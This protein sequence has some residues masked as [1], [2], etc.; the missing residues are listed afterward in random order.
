[1]D[2]ASIEKETARFWIQCFS[3]LFISGA[4]FQV[5]AADWIF[6]PNLTVREVFSDNIRQD[7]NNKKSALVTEVDPG[8][9]LRTISTINTFNLRYRMQNLYNAGGNSNIDINHQLALNSKYRLIRNR[10][11]VD[12]QSSISQQNTSNRRIASD[13]LTGGSNTTVTT[14]SISPYWTPHFKG[15][16]TGIVRLRYNRISTSGG[17]QN[18]SDTNTYSESIRFNSGHDFSRF[19]WSASFNNQQNQRSNGNDV[20]F[21]SS[22]FRV[23]YFFTRKLSS[24]IQVGHQSNQF[25]STT[26]S[27]R[28]GLYYTAGLFWRPSMRFSVQAGYGNN[29]FVTVNISPI[30]RITWSTTYFNND[31]GTNRGSRWQS[32]LRYY[33]RR[34]NWQFSYSENTVTTQQILLQRQLVIVPGINTQTNQPQLFGFIRDLPTLTDEVF[35]NKRATLSV[36]FRTGKSN[37]NFNGYRSRRIFQ[38]SQNNEDVYGASASW[39]WNFSQ[40]SRSTIRVLWQTTEGQDGTSDQRFEGNLRLTRNIANFAGSRSVYGSVQYRFIN[41]QS[42]LANNEFLENR[43][44]ASIS[45]RF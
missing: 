32:S 17:S 41:Q 28:N 2:M 18:F 33:T 6:R 34:S 36:S 29:K 31:I 27:N 37:L 40:R 8:F 24:F 30:R 11:Y 5:F 35:I 39:N 3:F 43:I 22:Q 38:V 42:D 26:N 16:A 45:M 15:F 25:Q 13:N 20:N 10:V 9:N 12:T 7:A 44:S 19:T 4:S 1:M 14:F 21:Q 23:N